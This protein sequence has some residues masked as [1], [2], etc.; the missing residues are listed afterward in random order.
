VEAA[1][2]KYE[3]AGDAYLAADGKRLAAQEVDVEA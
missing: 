2:I 3:A 1:R